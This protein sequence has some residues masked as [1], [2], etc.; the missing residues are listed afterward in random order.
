MLQY[1]QQCSLWHQVVSVFAH[2]YYCL[3]LT[4]EGI[5]RKSGVKSRCSALCERFRR[6]ARSL[7]LKEGEHQVDDVS[8][9]LKCFLRE[10]KEVLFTSEDAS[11]WLSTAGK[12]LSAVAALCKHGL[13]KCVRLFNLCIVVSV[14]P[15]ITISM[16]LKLWH[17]QS[18]WISGSR[19]SIYSLLLQGWGG[20]VTFLHVLMTRY[21]NITLL[22]LTCVLNL[23]SIAMYLVLLLFP[24]FLSPLLTYQ[25]VSIYFTL[26]SSH[27]VQFPHALSFS[28]MQLLF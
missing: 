9:T 17:L 20:A 14:H 6:D 24:L 12:I 8:S 3:G 13:L 7:R 28:V 21:I 5:Y 4:S 15:H 10:L 27:P 18:H 1:V 11:K 22:W 16:R 26:P 23:R 25:F 2:S 19:S